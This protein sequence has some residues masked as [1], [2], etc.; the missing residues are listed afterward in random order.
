MRW[1]D[2][3]F[4]HWPLKPDILRPFIPQGL[5]LDTREGWAWIA[6]VPFRMTG[7]RLR[8]APQPCSLAFPELNVRTYVKCGGKSGIW[9]FSLDATNRFAVRLARTWYRLPYFDAN[10]TVQNRSDRIDYS[11][12]RV[13][14]GALPAELRMQY[15]P[16]GNAFHAQLSTLEHWLIERYCLFA[17]DRKQRVRCS[18]IHHPPWQLQLAEASFERNTMTSPLEIQLPP[19]PPLLHFSKYQDVVAWNVSIHPVN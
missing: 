19:Q 6:V 10:M 4:A 2:L 5:E 11:S 17:I 3:L 9:F 15:S 13:H 14:H 1:H 16:R 18:D 8:F 12:T 7:V